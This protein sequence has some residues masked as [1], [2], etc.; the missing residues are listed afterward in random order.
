MDHRANDAWAVVPNKNTALRAYGEVFHWDGIGR[1]LS[2]SSG[3]AE[4]T[5]VSESGPDDLRVVDR[6]GTI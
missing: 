4:L 2:F 5:G 6:Q 1:Y 3:T